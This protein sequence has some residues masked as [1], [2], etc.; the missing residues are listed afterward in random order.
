METEKRLRLFEE[1]LFE[2]KNRS[3][4]HTF[5]P[6]HPKLKRTILSLIT[7]LARK[8]SFEE[9]ELYNSAVT[10]AWEVLGSFSLAEDVDW[11]QVISGDDKLNLNRIVKAIVRKIEHEL[12]AIANPNTR[13]LYDPETGGK[14]FVTVNFESLDRPL[15]DEAGDVVGSLVEEVSESFF[16]PS[17]TYAKNPFLE[18]FRNNRHEFLTARQNEFIDGLSTGLLK[19]DSDY[20][21]DNDFEKLAGMKTHDLDRIKKRIKERTLKAWEE[22][23][24]EMP[25]LTRR[26]SYLARQIKEWKA[27]LELADSDEQLSSQNARLSE[28]IRS[29]EFTVDFVY[30]ALDH[31][32][33][34]T[35]GFVAY[36]K[37]ETKEIAPTSLYEI[38][39]LVVAEVER[40][41]GELARISRGTLEKSPDQELRDVNAKRRRD[42]KEFT[43]EQP[44]YWYDAN[45]ELMRVF[46]SNLKEYKIMDLNAFGHLTD[47]RDF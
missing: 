41:A 46:N 10:I 9:R 23:R 16:A 44:C 20:I 30:D 36:L 21:D 8:G 12:P 5:V 18:W 11:D 4:E 43:Q 24:R 47:K 2:L 39:V 31:D 32:I 17:F 38:Y 19:K 15:Y 40:L 33:S 42:Y 45:G 26:G 34:A 7:A 29:R 27:F 13:R 1:V 28:W 3:T 6:R 37:D 25:E 14:V 35:K 22:H